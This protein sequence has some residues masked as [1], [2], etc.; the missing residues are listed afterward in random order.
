MVHAWL[1]HGT[2][3]GAWFKSLTISASLCSV[4]YQM[5]L[6]LPN[7]IIVLHAGIIHFGC[8]LED[9][10]IWT[11]CPSYLPQ[12]LKYICCRPLPVHILSVPH[13]LSG[14]AFSKRIMR[15]STKT[16]L[17]LIVA[18][19]LV[20]FTPKAV[21]P[22]MVPDLYYVR[23]CPFFLTCFYRADQRMGKIKQ[24]TAPS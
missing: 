13:R 3:P 1:R 5:G 12:L 2:Q 11:V 22:L 9:P 23:T 18:D 24:K 8:F 16:H 4:A 15:R 6:F 14:N 7:L 19:H 21:T 10:K 20:A 17:D